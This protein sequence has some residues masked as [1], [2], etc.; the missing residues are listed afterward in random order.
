MPSVLIVSNGHGEDAVGALLARRLRASGVTV[1]AYPL[2]G[3][4]EAYADIT[5]LDPRRA[6]PSGGFGFRGSWK[7]LAAD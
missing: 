6:F 7:M 1:F 4:G 2:V 5:R 3:T